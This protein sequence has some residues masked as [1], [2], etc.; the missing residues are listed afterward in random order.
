MSSLEKLIK[1]RRAL[2]VEIGLA[3]TGKPKGI[4]A[5]GYLDALDW[6]LSLAPITFTASRAQPAETRWQPIETAPK[7]GTRMLL[8]DHS[9]IVFC[10]NYDTGCGFWVGDDGDTCHGLT[11]WMPLPAPPTEKGADQ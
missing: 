5:A 6:L 10:G 1:K 8:T 3:H 2:V 4:E 11:H 7:D 9:E